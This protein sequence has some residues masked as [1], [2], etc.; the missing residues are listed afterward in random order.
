MDLR[1]N[2][3]SFQT[4]LY[5]LYPLISCKLLL[6]LSVTLHG[7]RIEELGVTYYQIMVW[8]RK[9]VYR[10]RKFKG[11]ICSGSVWSRVIV[12][13]DFLYLSLPNKCELPFSRGLNHARI[14]AIEQ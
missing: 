7:F 14:L 13:Q 5:T 6:L 2:V 1:V 3:H 11:V 4:S 10:T 9:D 8:S 12:P